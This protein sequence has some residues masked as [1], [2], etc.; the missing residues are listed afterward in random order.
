MAPLVPSLYVLSFKYFCVLL[1]RECLTIITIPNNDVM[2]SFLL[3]IVECHCVIIYDVLEPM[4]LLCDSVR[5]E[6]FHSAMMPSTS[7]SV[8]VFFRCTFVCLEGPTLFLSR[9]IHNAFDCL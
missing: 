5:S 4:G 1:I 2:A 7:L 3:F 6:V 8:F 9:T